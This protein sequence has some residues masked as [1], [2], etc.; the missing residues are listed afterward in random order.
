MEYAPNIAPAPFQYMANGMSNHYSMV[1]S[2]IVFTAYIG[3]LIVILI[4]GYICYNIYKCYRI[5]RV[6]KF[7]N[8]TFRRSSAVRTPWQPDEDPADYTLY[9]ANEPTYAPQGTPLPLENTPVLLQN[10][11]AP[12]VDG[13]PNAPKSLAMFAYNKSRPECCYGVNGGYSTSG[14]CVC[15]SKEQEQ[16]LSAVGGNRS[17]GYMGIS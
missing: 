1:G 9:R 7:E 17:Y 15:V 10:T 5:V 13:T 4:I 11:N 12:E 6:E 16:Y 8:P 3:Y 14:G 2:G